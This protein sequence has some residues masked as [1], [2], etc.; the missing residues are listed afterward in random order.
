MEV[1]HFISFPL[2][3]SWLE[4]VRDA[5][6]EDIQKEKIMNMTAF[7]I[8]TARSLITCN[9]PAPRKRG[10]PSSNNPQTEPPRKAHNVESLPTNTTRY[11]GCEHW[12]R[13]VN[14][15]SAKTVQERRLQF[16]VTH[17]VSKV[18]SFLCLTAARLLLLISQESKIDLPKNWN[19][20][21]S[22]F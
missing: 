10:R 1:S 21:L 20:S 5:S 7:Q 17:S 15:S 3:N 11:D 9:K 6:A 18:C 22:I 16:K 13:H 14:L 4:Y 19:A 2:C 12:T 8:S